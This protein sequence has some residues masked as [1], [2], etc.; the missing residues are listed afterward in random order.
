[1]HVTSAGLCFL[2]VCL[3]ERSRFKLGATVQGVLVFFIWM[4]VLYRLPR[5]ALSLYYSPDRA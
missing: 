4:Q 5:L 3:G 1:M 2:N